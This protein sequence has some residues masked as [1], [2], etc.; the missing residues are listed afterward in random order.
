M[1]RWK[2]AE[3]LKRRG[4]TAYRLA[5]E[6]GLTVPAV[7]RLAKQNAQMGRVE[8][9]TLDRLCDALG[10]QPGELLEHIP[11]KPKTRKRG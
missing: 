10:V 5:Q 3:L 7:Y 8:G 2:I 4:W 11:D 9:N 1:V 6:T